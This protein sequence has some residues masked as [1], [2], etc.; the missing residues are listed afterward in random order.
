MER[1]CVKFFLKASKR[2]TGQQ[3]FLLVLLEWDP[4]TFGVKPMFVC[5]FRIFFSLYLVK[6]L[7]GTCFGRAFL[8]LFLKNNRWHIKPMIRSCYCFMI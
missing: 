7:S 4:F 3:L 5:V 1:F 8:L 2:K 6:S